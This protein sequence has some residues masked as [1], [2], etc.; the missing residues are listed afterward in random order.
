VRADAHSLASPH[1]NPAGS[2]TVENAQKELV[3]WFPEG[4]VDN[5]PVLRSQIYE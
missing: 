1:P 4:L 5:N 2:D 3:M